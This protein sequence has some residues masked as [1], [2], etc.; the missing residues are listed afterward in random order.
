MYFFFDM[1][2]ETCSVGCAYGGR[3]TGLPSQALPTRPCAPWPA[4]LSD[5][6]AQTLQV[7][8]AHVTEGW[9]VACCA[10][11]GLANAGA[12]ILMSP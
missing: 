10:Q 11:H 3:C 4:L 7:L 8:F 2:T 6:L 9:K 12:E 1:L 5:V